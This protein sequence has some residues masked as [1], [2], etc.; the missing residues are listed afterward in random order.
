[1]LS[2]SFKTNW[3][4]ATGALI[5]VFCIAIQTW[6]VMQQDRL[7]TLAAERANGLVAVR[8]LEEHVAQTM[9]DGLQKLEAMANTI[10]P[11]AEDSA[12]VTR[13]LANHIEKDERFIKSVR[14]IDNF[15]H[16]WVSSRDFPA[17]QVDIADK[18]EI[19]FLLTHPD[20]QQI[21]IGHPYQ[22]P[23]D[24]QL[25]IPLVKNVFN[26]KKQRVGII[27]TDIRLNYF[28]DLYA[29]V[30]KENNAMLA[31]IANDGFVIVRSPFE[32]R[33]LDRDISRD[34]ASQIVNGDDNEGALQ[35]QDWLDDEFERL[36]VYRKLHDF[37]LTV[38]YGR[39]LDSILAPWQER[40]NARIGITA[41][42]TTILGLVLFVLAWQLQ[43][44]RQVEARNK[45]AE[46]QFSHV[47]SRSP[48]P[49]TLINL[50]SVEIEEVNQAWL[51]LFGYQRQDILGDFKQLQKRIWLDHAELQEFAK[52]LLAGQEVDR[53]T[54]H[55]LSQDGRSLTCWLSARPYG[56]QGH[57]RYIITSQD[58]TRQ[59]AAELAI[60]ELNQELEQRVSQR[61]ANL[62]KSNDELA[63]ALVS[64]KAMQSE[65]I[66]QE[67]L[68]SLGALVAGIAHEL[69]TP[70]GNSVTIAST[71][72]DET[73][74]MQRL[75]DQGQ[76]K[77]STFFEFLDKLKN[78]TDVLLRSLSRASELILS[79]KH[80]A[81]DQSSEMRRQFDLGQVIE[82]IVLTNTALF[83]KTPYVLELHF[84]TEI[85]M[86]SFPG[87]L[88][89]IITNLI[90]NALA[91]GFEGCAQGK[92]TISATLMDANWV[93]LVFAD[94]GVGIPESHLSRVYDPFFTTK[95]GQ[96]GS[97]L[98]LNIVY[99]LVTEV[100][101]G[102]IELHSETGKGTRISLN[103][104]ITAP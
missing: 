31:L 71:I 13:A 2:T 30:A 100:L 87:A 34:S 68:A 29:R 54:A 73:N 63:Q 32:A 104:P 50:D 90:T 35:D 83:A 53:F 57:R 72:I 85:N 62:E 8:I 28:A 36:Y 9:A 65:V 69:N 42:L 15:G 55:L 25:V 14:F 70:I 66:R 5:G 75:I 60:R 46:L 102:R 39:D 74:A 26:Q 22:S 44:L 37:P 84:A 16:S 64:L 38:V 99:N 77:R 61:T 21:Q 76:L 79:F 4:I 86:N 97:G 101:G 94:D 67:K 78:G 91:H 18:S 49:L 89:Q 10:A 1:M 40:S 98:G 92:M 56:D 96:G 43:K 20:F 88:G 7:Q 17:H 3:L 23:Y 59:L 58:V 6:Y 81:V 27:S 48:N 103:L 93:N 47:F 80:V 95:F 33:Y 82:E 19:R 24:S 12:W 11:R 52:Q 51:Q 41:I 45:Q